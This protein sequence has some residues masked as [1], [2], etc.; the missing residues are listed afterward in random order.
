MTL[1]S[2]STR[3]QPRTREYRLLAKLRS[4]GYATRYNEDD[5]VHRIMAP[6]EYGNTTVGLIVIR[7]G[8]INYAE[9][10]NTVFP[11]WGRSNVDPL[12]LDALAKL[13][14]VVDEGRRK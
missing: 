1:G 14:H 6:A 13:E 12:Y 3:P 8:R 5:G 11:W 2:L 4:G 10:D 9:F 7:E